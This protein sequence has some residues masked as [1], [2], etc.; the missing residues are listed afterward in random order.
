MP[1]PRALIDQLQSY[2][3]LRR[4][5]GWDRTNEPTRLERQIAGMSLAEMLDNLPKACDLGTK[6]NHKDCKRS[7]IG[8]KHHIIMSK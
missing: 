3:Q 5:G 1:T 6:K 4:I 2:L 7:W 8:Y